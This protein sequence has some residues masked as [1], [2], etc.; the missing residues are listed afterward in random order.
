MTRMRSTTRSGPG[1]PR[2]P[3]GLSESQRQ[4][5]GTDYA[6]AVICRGLAA[7]RRPARPGLDRTLDRRWALA[8]G[9]GSADSERN[10][11]ASICPCR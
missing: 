2:E 10:V 3:G 11:A 9:P 4:V 8:D 5:R 1:G 6:C 7:G